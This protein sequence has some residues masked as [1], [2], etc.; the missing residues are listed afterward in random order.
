LKG[1]I[2][3]MSIKKNEIVI[4]AVL[5][6]FACIFPF[7]ADNYIL[8]VGIAVLITALLGQSWNIMSGYSG[9]F[10]FG[11]AVFFGIGAYTSSLLYVDFR[12]SPWV[13]MIVGAIIAAVVGVIIG[14][15]S[16]RYKLRGDFFALATLAVAEICRILFNNVKVFKGAVGVLIPYLTDPLEYQFGNDIAFFF[17]ILILV[18]IATIFIAFMRKS[19]LGLNLVAI[20]SNQDAAAAVGVNVLKYKLIAIAVSAAFA[21]LAGTFYAQ[22]YGFIDPSTVF[23]ATISVEAIV[24]CIVGGSGTLAGP[25]LG[26]FIIIPLQEICNSAFPDISGINMIIYGLVIVLFIL[27]CPNG[28]LGIINDKRKKK[29]ATK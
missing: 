28:I 29:E 19:K 27:F 4:I 3:E 13:G 10:S 14:F 5:G 12:I 17:V 7:F 21:A 9:Q 24:P 25:L 20:K 15:L 1:E 26:A 23:A 6:I 16:F 18:A 22:Y 2:A 8:S 11:H